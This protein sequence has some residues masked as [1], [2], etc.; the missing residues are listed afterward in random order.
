MMP[1]QFLLYNMPEKGVEL[2]KTWSFKL[3][4]EHIEVF[5]EPDSYY[6]KEFREYLFL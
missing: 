4:T 6:F 5:D 3:M 1:L 2:E